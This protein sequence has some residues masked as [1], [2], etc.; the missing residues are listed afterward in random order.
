[1]RT[2]SSPS[3]AVSISISVHFSI[4]TAISRFSSL[5]SASKSLFPLQQPALSLTG[6]EPSED[7]SLSGVRSVFS[8]FLSSRKVTVKTEPF[9]RT[10]L[11]PDISVHHIHN[12]FGNGH[13]QPGS[14]N[15]LHIAVPGPFKRI[16]NLFQE[17]L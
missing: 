17:F 3:Q 15:F 16:K 2:A 4:S 8:S 14:C 7:T 10:A 12:I 6:T 9:P 11:Y 13:S 5:S 1:M